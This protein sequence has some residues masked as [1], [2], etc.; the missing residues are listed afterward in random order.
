[1]FGENS[2]ANT[3]HPEA[4]IGRGYLCRIFA[5]GFSPKI[6]ALNLGTTPWVLTKTASWVFLRRN[7]Q[8]SV[9]VEETTLSANDL[10]GDIY[11]SKNKAYLLRCS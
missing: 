9:V 11:F 8:V 5:A 2:A 4:K 7:F 6:W 3:R 10:G 1:M